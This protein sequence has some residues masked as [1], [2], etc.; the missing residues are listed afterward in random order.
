MNMKTPNK[1]QPKLALPADAR[2]GSLLTFD[3]YGSLFDAILMAV[4]VQ[5]IAVLFIYRED[6]PELI[7]I[8]LET[9]KDQNDDVVSR[10]AL[11]DVD[12]MLEEYLEDESEYVASAPRTVRGGQFES[13]RSKH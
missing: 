7:T 2:P 6:F 1:K 9:G 13:N 5:S 3:Y 11:C 12:E 4:D 8:N 10:I